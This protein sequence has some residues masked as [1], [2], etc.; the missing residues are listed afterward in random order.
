MSLTLEISK[1]LF[2]LQISFMVLKNTSELVINMKAVCYIYQFNANYLLFHS[3]SFLFKIVKYFAMLNKFRQRLANTKWDQLTGRRARLIVILIGAL[4]LFV[5]EFI[6]GI[7]VNSVSLVAMSF[8]EV[9]DASAILIAIV[10]HYV[11]I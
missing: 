7:W 3:F 6:L 11:C 1:Y 5:I 10:A 2:E 9:N 8:H 4:I